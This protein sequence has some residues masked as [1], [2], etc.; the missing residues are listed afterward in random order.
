MQVVQ[1]SFTTCK[2]RITAV[3]DAPDRQS[4]GRGRRVSSIWKGRY[5]LMVFLAIFRDQAKVLNAFSKKVAQPL[6]VVWT[7]NDQTTFPTTDVDPRRTDTFGDLT[8]RPA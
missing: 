7:R 2:K 6:T 3:R 1:N 4:E 8:L 5:L